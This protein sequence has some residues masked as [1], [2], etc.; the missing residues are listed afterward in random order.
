MKIIEDVNIF[1]AILFFIC[2]FYQY[3]YIIVPFLKKDFK[4]KKEQKEYNYAVLISARNEE[5]VIGNL[6]DS[7]NKQNYPKDKVDIFVVADNCTDTTAEVARLKHAIVFERKNKKRVG[8]GFALN[9]LINKIKKDYDISKYEG[10]F[11][12]DADNIIDPNYIKEMNKTHNDGYEIITSYRNSKNYGDNWISAGYSLWFLRES[13]YLNHARMALHTSCAVS[14]TGFMFSR[15]ILKRINDWH[16][17]LLTEDIEF[18]I[19]NVIHGEKIGYSSKA[20]L[21]DEQP[22]KFSQSW[23]QRLRWSKG[24]LQVFSKYGKD[25]LGNFGNFSCFDMCMTTMPAMFISITMLIVD[26][27]AIVITLLLKENFMIP[28]RIVL[29]FLI[30]IY[31]LLFIVGGVTT[32]TEWKN[33]YTSNLKKI[34]YAFTFPLFMFTYMPISVCSLFK[35]V[36]WT[37][38]SHDEAKELEDIIIER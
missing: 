30:D 37:P 21:Y 24:F 23:N 8:K 17:F 15:K 26:G 13:K 12:I 20:I 18:T 22:T 29:N 7:I 3:L 34:L 33:I 16:F 27:I 10:F 2:Y 5:N 25:L 14:G 4:H 1:L 19:D 11:V 35:K 28:V 36:E 38:I 9:F 32:I 6:I 31:F